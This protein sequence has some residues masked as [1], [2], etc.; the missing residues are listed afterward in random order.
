VSGAALEFRLNDA[1]L[2]RRAGEIGSD[3]ARA[4]GARTRRLM[5]NIAAHGIASTM[6]RFEKGEGPGGVRWPLSLRALMEGG[7]TLV[8]SGRLRDSFGVEVTDASAEWGTNVEYGGIHQFGGRTAPHVIVP[9]RAKALGIPG[10]GPRKKV[11][12]PGSDIPARPFLGLD[13]ADEAAIVDIADSWL[14]GLV[15]Q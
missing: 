4:R 12:H 9:K 14:K 2:K 5:E 3:L 13:A 10:I 7:Q 8:K 11:N 1:E 15:R 6:R